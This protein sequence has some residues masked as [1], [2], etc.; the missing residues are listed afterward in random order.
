MNAYL[1]V[2]FLPLMSMKHIKS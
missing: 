2:V 1:L